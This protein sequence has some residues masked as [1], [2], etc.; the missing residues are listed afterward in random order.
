MTRTL[1]MSDQGKTRTLT[2][3]DQGKMLLTKGKPKP[4]TFSNFS[5]ILIQLWRRRCIIRD[6]SG[7]RSTYARWSPSAL[8]TSSEAASCLSSMALER[9]YEFTIGLCDPALRPDGQMKYDYLTCHWKPTQGYKFW[10]LEWRVKSK[11]MYLSSQHSWRNK[12][13]F[14]TVRQRKGAFC[15]EIR[16]QRSRRIKT[17]QTCVLTT[18]ELLRHNCRFQNPRSKGVSQ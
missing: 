3:S 14:L 6:W 16:S 2:M 12:Y 10:K 11:I 15:Q 8:R 1:T 13:W 9:T 5:K 4:I 17:W 18:H 7:E